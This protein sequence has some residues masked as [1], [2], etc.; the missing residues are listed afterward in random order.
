[1]ASGEGGGGEAVLQ[2]DEATHRAQLEA[3]GLELNVG[4]VALSINLF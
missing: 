1:M 3:A 4:S 2:Q